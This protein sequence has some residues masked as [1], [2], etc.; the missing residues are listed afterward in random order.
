MPLQFLM[1]HLFLIPLQKREQMKIIKKT[2]VGFLLILSGLQFIRPQKNESVSTAVND[3]KTKFAMTPQIQNILKT[4][5]YDCHSN[6][7]I[8]PW[9]TNIQPVGLWMQNHVNEGKDEL[10][11]AEFA[12]YSDKRADHKMDEVIEVLQKN[13]M[14]LSSYTLIHGGAKLSDEQ[15]LVLINWA[16]GIVAQINYEVEK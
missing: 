1:R 4:S 5:C 6:N 3:I 8:Y 12:T 2:A 11:F 9:Y 7:T 10:N 14:P 15:K 13:E 16:K